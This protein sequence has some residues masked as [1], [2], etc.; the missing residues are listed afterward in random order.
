MPIFVPPISRR[1]FLTRALVAGAGMA[2]GPKLLAATQS[3]DKSLW[4][5]VSD[6]H[7][8]ARQGKMHCHV[9]MHDHFSSVVREITEMPANPAGIFIN[10]DCAFYSGEA[11]DYATFASMLEPLR[12][13]RIPIHLTLGN[14]DNRERFWE[15]LEF[16]RTAVRPLEDKQAA[17]I[18]TPYVNWYLLDSLEETNSCPGLIGEQ[19]LSWLAKTLDEN[20]GKPALIMLHHSPNGEGRDTLGLKDTEALFNIIRPRSQVKACIYGHTHVWNVKSDASGIHLVNLPPTSFVYSQ[21][22]PIG[23]VSATLT[24][25]GMQLQLRCTDQRHAAHGEVRQLKWRS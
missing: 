23:W 9:N 14:H 5:L 4:A 12:A 15:A 19:Q 16:E 3:E 22:A 25:N 1:Q 24:D 13:A 7:I 6:P 8:A 20:R 10:G 21:D 11:E 18:S 17:F 2:L